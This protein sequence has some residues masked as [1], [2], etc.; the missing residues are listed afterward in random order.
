M[1]RDQLRA[2]R[3]CFKCHEKYTPGHKC[4]VKSLHAL[5][6][7]EDD[8]DPEVLSVPVIEWIKEVGVEQ[9]ASHADA[10]ITM[11]SDQSASKLQT[12]KFKGD[13]DHIPIC[14]LID[15]GST[16]SFVNPSLIDTERWPVSHTTPLNVR[17]AN[18]TAMTTSTK[19]D[20]FCFTLQHHQLSGSVRLLNIQ[21]YDVILGMDW[22]SLHGP[23]MIDWET[24]KVHLHKDGEEFQLTVQQEMAEIK[25]CQSILQPLKEASKGQL[26]VVAQVSTLK[27]EIVSTQVEIH[28]QLQP[29]MA[30]FNHVFQEPVQLPPQRSIDHKIPLLPDSKPIS[31]RPYRYS[32]FQKLEIER[33]IEELISQSFI[34]QSSSPYSSPVLLVKKKDNSWR[35]CIDYRQLNAMTVKN[36]YPIPI[37]DDL[38]DELKGAVYFSKIDLRSGYH[39]IRMKEEDV[40]KTAF[41]THHG[42]YEFVVMPF[43][44]TNAPATFQSLMNGLFQ[45]YARKF[46]LVFFD[47]ILIYSKSIED[48]VDHVSAALQI[49]AD[50]GLYAKLSKCAFGVQQIEYLGHIISAQGVSTDPT[51][52]DAM[53][54]WPVPKTVKELRGFLG[55]TG[56]YRKF[57]KDYGTISKPLTDLTKKNAFYWSDKSQIAFDQLKKAMTVAPVL[58][59]PDYSQQFTIETDASALGIGAVLMQNHKPI[60]FLS[61]SLGVKS[62]ALSTYEKELLALLTAVKKWRHY[63]MANPFVIRTDQISL[64]HLL[65]QKVTTAL[66]HKGLC[67]LLGLNYTIEYKRGKENKVADALSRVQCQNWSVQSI[68]GGLGAVSEIIPSWI[69]ELLSSYSGDTWIEELQQKAF[70]EATTSNPTYTAHQGVVR[71]KGRICVGK[72]GNWRQQI[73]QS[74]HD[75]SVGGHSGIN[76]TYNKVRRLFYWPGLK[77]SV[78]DYVASC[79]NCQLNKGEHSPYPGLLQP[80]PIPSE[81]WTSVGLDFITG[82]PKSKGRDVI[83]VV[84]DR[85]T[86]YGHFIPLTHPYNAAVV[87]QVFVDHIYKLHGLPQNLVSDRDPIFTSQFWR[88]LMDKIGIQLNM[89]TA[90]HPQSDGQTE[91]LNQCLEQ[92]LRC[93]IFEQQKK[94]VSWL[95]F[96]EYWY[97]TSHHQSLGMTPFQALYGYQPPLL[98]LGDTI[99]SQDPSVNNWLKDRQQ[100]LTII[101]DNLVKAQCRM[102]KYADLH[103]TERHFEVGDW[104]YL[105]AQT[106]RQSSLAGVPHSKLSSKYFGPYEIIHR[107]GPVAYRLNFP[108]DTQLHPVIHVSQL[109]KQIGAHFRP[110]AT[111]P[112]VG[113]DGKLHVEPEKML[114]RRFIKRGL[115]GVPQIKIKWSNLS[116]EEAS[117]EDYEELR[118]RYPH[119]I[120]EVENQLKEGGMS[121]TEVI[122]TEAVTEE[123]V[124][125][126]RQADAVREKVTV[127][128][129]E[130]TE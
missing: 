45:P 62:Q 76:V 31:I 19:C 40:F 14:V 86:K 66:Q 6:M 127:S 2:L 32:Y 50:N 111:L 24:G 112:W 101:K 68:E 99:K 88:E 27:E 60:A 28:P 105:K 25:L 77:Q 92:Y 85:L 26:L 117:W 109:K 113:P 102:K 110:A 89:S 52:V 125:L 116:E 122:G 65:E 64:K 56:Y 47:D 30:K 123:R 93:M 100:A 18:G 34:R 36:K 98:P 42:H 61:K 58:T 46:I 78:H 59:L 12:L 124:D 129:T 23:M 10:V 22:L 79:H 126:V 130:Q 13:F 107:V 51:K 119:F 94:W 69:Q 38:L 70:L 57:I 121:G 33:I 43:G 39:Q 75:S 108:S 87:A 63:L 1:S 35:L 118:M 114:D 8:A 7:E 67:T 20:S 4:T 84:V 44:L 74:L 82:L 15:T 81:A 55:L 37:I 72:A 11:C 48:H 5:Q 97:N 73:L 91:R 80:L 54:N 49:L 71:Y 29:I 9:C 83:L 120:L 103:R 128:Q 21:G 90:Y 17:I 95:S 41:R 96:A 16:H 53:V 3:L 106:Y 115:V 104:V